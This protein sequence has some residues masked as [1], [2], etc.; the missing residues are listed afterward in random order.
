MSSVPS[1]QDVSSTAIGSESRDRYRIL[2]L[3]KDGSELLAA[4]SRPPFSLPYVE[5][6]AC[7]RVAENVTAAFRIRYGIRAICLFEPDLPVMTGEERPL[8][9]VM[10]IRETDGALP[11][12]SR[13]LPTDSFCDRSWTDSQDCAAVTAAMRQMHQFQSG[14]MRGPFGKSGWIDELFSWTQRE[15]DRYGLRL[16]GELRQL[17]AS[18]TFALLRLETDR[19][20][21]WFK[22]VGEPNLQEFPISVALSRLFPSFVP[23]VIATRPE[24]YSWL[25]M[26]SAGSSLYETPSIEAW[27][28]ASETLA[29]LEIESCGRSDQLFEAGCKDL[30]IPSLFALVDP[31]MDLMSELMEQQRKTP[32]PTLDS[33]ALRMLGRQIKDVLRAM[34][35]LSIPNTLGH[36]DFNPGNILCS[37]DRCIFLD[38]AEAYIGPPFLTFEFLREQWLRRQRGDTGSDMDISVPYQAA[39]QRILSPETICAAREFAPVLGVFTYASGTGA[40]E[41]RTVL[42]RTRLPVYLRSMTRRMHAEMLRLQERRRLCCS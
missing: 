8:Y 36:R 11:Q 10:E 7:E 41:D 34:E 25:T 42:Q 26:E 40:L 20:G 19:F 28:C 18:P 17:N 29:R 12:D 4:G 38:W 31:F 22:A 16:T 27:K 35:D 5:V 3:R 14:K 32:P 24:W 6:P 39:W 15:I 2:L 13:W 37:F 30:R 33:G 9:Q 1:I 21:V 23:R